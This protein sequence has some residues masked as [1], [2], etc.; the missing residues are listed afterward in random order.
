MSK[1][2]R[3]RPR[4]ISRES[5]E[6]SWDRIFGSKSK[7]ENDSKKATNISTDTKKNKSE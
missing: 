5:Y 1:G 4:Q 7:S 2:S 6:S 3:Q